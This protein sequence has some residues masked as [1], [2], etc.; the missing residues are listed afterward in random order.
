M[1]KKISKQYISETEKK[2]FDNELLPNGIF[3]YNVNHSAFDSILKRLESQF[4][5]INDYADTLN[6]AIHRNGL[7]FRNSLN[8]LN[9]AEVMDSI[10]VQYS[11]YKERCNNMSQW[12]RVT[13][14][15]II[16]GFSIEKELSKEIQYDFNL[17]Y[18]NEL[19][20][21]ITDYLKKDLENEFNSWK[22]ELNNPLANELQFLIDKKNECEKAITRAK[23]LNIKFFHGK[24]STLLYKETNELTKLDII[25]ER[26]NELS[27]PQQSNEV[28]KS[29]KPINEQPVLKELALFHVYLKTKITK[30]NAKDYLKNTTHSSGKKFKQDFDFFSLSK[31]RIYGGTDR[32]NSYKDK[33]LKKVIE[34]LKA[35]NNINAIKDAENDL[36]TFEKNIQ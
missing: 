25:N 22:I 12:L 29:N 18:D 14:D 20:I 15:L 19:K 33:Y 8:G 21:I 36:N 7:I 30:D 16:K 28:I 11:Y 4:E 10:K 23:E 24:P 1:K 26:I 17:W 13:K 34:M 32:S 5:T 9:R 3:Y 31:N 6:T 35:T 2:E 27:K